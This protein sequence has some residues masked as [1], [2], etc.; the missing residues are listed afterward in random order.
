MEQQRDHKDG[1]TDAEEPRHEGADETQSGQKGKKR[2][3]HLA[4]RAE[5]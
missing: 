3:V 2:H 1:A 4:P 5:E